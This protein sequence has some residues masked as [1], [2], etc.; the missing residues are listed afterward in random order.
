M[1][2]SVQRWQTGVPAPDNLFCACC[3]IPVARGRQM[4][5][6][7]VQDGDETYIEAYVCGERC[8]ERWL[9]G[10]E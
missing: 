6:V 7:Q 4:I 5:A 8:A 2:T 9:E 10:V 3:R 1:V